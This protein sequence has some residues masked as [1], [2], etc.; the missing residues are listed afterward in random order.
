[1][2]SGTHNHSQDARNAEVLVYINGELIPR[3]RA[4]VSVF[5]SGWASPPPLKRP[6]TVRVFI[7][8][9]G[10]AV[11]PPQLITTTLVICSDLR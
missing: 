2:A 3:D 5:D 7:G 11:P 4:R 10:L 9:R 6:R 1:M 8:R